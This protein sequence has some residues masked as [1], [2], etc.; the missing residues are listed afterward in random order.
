MARAYSFDLRER[1]VRAVASGQSCRAVA[2]S[3]QHQCRERC[4]VVAAFS[5]DR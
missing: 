3:F 2:A 1:V 4:E 5:R